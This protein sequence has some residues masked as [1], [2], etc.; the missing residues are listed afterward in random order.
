MSRGIRGAYYREAPEEP[1]QWEIEDGGVQFFERAGI[2]Y[3]PEAEPT[4][5]PS[6]IARSASHNSISSTVSSQSCSGSRI[7]D[8]NLAII[9]LFWAGGSE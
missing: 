6:P 9:R 5:I 3:D 8:V 1:A 7:T 2:R 4:I